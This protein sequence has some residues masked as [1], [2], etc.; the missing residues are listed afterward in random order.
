M[1]VDRLYKFEHASQGSN[2]WNLCDTLWCGPPG[3]FMIQEH[4]KKHFVATMT[5]PTSTTITT[6][7]T[8][9]TTTTAT[10]TTTIIIILSTNDNHNTPATRT[11]TQAP[12]SNLLSFPGP[13]EACNTSSFKQISWWMSHG[14]IICLAWIPIS[15]LISIDWWTRH[16]TWNMNTLSHQFSGGVSPHLNH[17]ASRKTHLA[18]KLDPKRGFLELT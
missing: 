3:Y 1:I 17:Q 12:W 15:H 18:E 7:N 6:T 13:Q 14:K 9:T 11:I 8:T 4:S 2:T 10:T 16:P 5:T